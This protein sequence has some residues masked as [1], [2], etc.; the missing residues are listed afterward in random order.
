MSCCSYINNHAQLA[1]APDTGLLTLHIANYVYDYTALHTHQ[2]ETHCRLKTT[3]EL[4]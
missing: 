2:V 4:C 3:P 1:A